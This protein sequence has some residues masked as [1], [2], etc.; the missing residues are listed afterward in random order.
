MESIR[1]IVVPENNKIELTVP[2]HF[3]G[4]TIEVIAFEIEEEKTSKSFKKKTF[5]AIKLDLS[6]YKFN[7]D[8]ANER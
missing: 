6:G 3:I 7:R 5:D 1:E 4:K 2:D 8:E